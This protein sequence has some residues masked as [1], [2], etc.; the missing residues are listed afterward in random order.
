MIFFH[1]GTS[2]LTIYLVT[3]FP[4]DSV[5]KTCQHA[6]DTGSIPGSVRYC[7]EGHGNPIQYSWQGNPW[8]EEPGR[9]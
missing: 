3:D 8:I 9:L 6:G 5:A 4:G 7:G 2:L 1:I